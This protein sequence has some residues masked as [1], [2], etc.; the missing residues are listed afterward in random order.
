[1]KKILS[2]LSVLTISGTTIP[3]IIAISSYER[4][5]RQTPPSLQNIITTV[6]IGQIEINDQEHI[7][8]RLREINHPILSRPDFLENM[9]IENITWTSAIIHARENIQSNKYPIP[10]SISFMINFSVYRPLISSIIR[11]TNLGNNIS[12]IIHG[13]NEYD[14]SFGN[15][16]DELRRLN[17][18]LPN[19]YQNIFN[20]L[21]IDYQQTTEHNAQLGL[22]RAGL[23]FYTDDRINVTFNNYIN[24]NLLNSILINYTNLGELPD[25]RPQTILQRVKELNPNIN[26]N[27][28]T[29]IENS[30]TENSAQISLNRT[31]RLF[32][33]IKYQNILTFS[34]Q[35]SKTSDENDKELI[36]N[37]LEDNNCQTNNIESVLIRTGSG[38]SSSSI[39]GSSDVEKIK[40]TPII[41][42][43]LTKQKIF[44]KF[45]N[46]SKEQK[47]IKLNEINQHYQNL[48]KTNK[49]I[50]KKKLEVLGTSLL[51]GGISAIG[52]K[53]IVG[54][55]GASG[56]I[57]AEGTE[58][59]PLLSASTTEN[60]AVAETVTAIETA[61]VEGTVLGA[62]ATTSLALAPETLGLSLVIGG[63]ITAGTSIM[64][65]INSDHKKIIKH[66]SHNQY[67][68]IEKYYKFLAHDQL[69]LGLDNSKWNKI[70]EIYQ[71]NS[72][73]YQ[74]FKNKV[75]S[76]ITNFH[77]ENHS[78]WDES[79]T[80]ND[81]DILIK[82]IYNNF[83]EL[84][85]HFSSYSNNQG[86][87]V[88]TNTVGSYFK[89]QQE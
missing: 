51:G 1:M 61:A 63:L 70:K 47:Q 4:H 9:V 64:W 40:S 56:A 10:A 83:Q 50:F 3:N 84:N 8:A 5:K 35:N 15:I 82:V 18:N 19:H 12:I 27:Y 30:I 2:L 28:F 23:E 22:I 76:I 58:L 32:A 81:I 44:D 34:I 38:T 79:I 41:K 52:T 80:N 11:N 77:K 25:N 54:S 17:P 7:I 14:V 53:I 26:I 42:A 57:S 46:L 37:K 66:E 6:N 73:N 75:K 20:F 29:I 21:A 86:W 13:L 49:T 31:N 24:L 65:W 62:E 59:A 72:N 74:E 45:N 48:S 85:N 69:K 89:I 78:G 68:E 88:V 36:K 33:F 55:G 43:L 71:E 39:G 60:L 67:N 16:I 87:K